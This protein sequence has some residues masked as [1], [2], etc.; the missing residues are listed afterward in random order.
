MYRKG[1][2][3]LINKET[4]INENIFIDLNYKN[5]RGITPLKINYS[6]VEVAS[7]ANRAYGM[8]TL[9]ENLFTSEVVKLW[10]DKEIIKKL[11]GDKLMEKINDV[12][13]KINSHIEYHNLAKNVSKYNI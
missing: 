6:I 10:G 12:E 9:S 2:Y 4:I 13:D 1:D 11:D 7:P 3:L 8:K 5:V